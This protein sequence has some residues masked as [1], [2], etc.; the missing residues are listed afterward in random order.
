MSLVKFSS[1]AEE[2][3]SLVSICLKIDLIYKILK[4]HCQIRT[5]VPLN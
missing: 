1:K 2:V 4:Y 3:L 5:R